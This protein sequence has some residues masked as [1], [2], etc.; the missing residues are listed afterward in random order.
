M[1]VAVVVVAAVLVVVAE[2]VLASAVVAAAAEGKMPQR[3]LADKT[4][5]NPRLPGR[6]E[7]EK[8]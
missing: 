8:S 5:A 3:E 6:I 1:T 4:I 7:T 2:V